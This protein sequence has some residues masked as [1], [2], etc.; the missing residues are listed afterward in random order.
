MPLQAEA[1]DA[2]NVVSDERM[3]IEDKTVLS[4]GICIKNS[5]VC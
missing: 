2:G 1:A 3:T 5:P 4:E